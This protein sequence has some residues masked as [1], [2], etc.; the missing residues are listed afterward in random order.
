MDSRS[1]CVWVCECCDCT[2]VACESHFFSDVVFMSLLTN[3]MY[4]QI[5]FQTG[6]VIAFLCSDASKWVNGQRIEVAGGINL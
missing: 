5:H 3:S 6:P 2:G 4:T 1:V